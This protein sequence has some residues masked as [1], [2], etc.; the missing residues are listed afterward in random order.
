MILSSRISSCHFKARCNH[1]FLT[2][3]R[4][5]IPLHIQLLCNIRSQDTIPPTATPYQAIYSQESTN[6]MSSEE[7]SSGGKGQTQD[8]YA[9]RSMDREMAYSTPKLTTTG[10]GNNE[11]CA[12]QSPKEGAH[13]RG[14]TTECDRLCCMCEC[15]S[16]DCSGC[17]GCCEAC[18]N[19]CS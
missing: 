17:D 6:T 10:T 2:H 4:R 9:R 11:A 19:A 1:H 14:G 8:P 13:L 16:M 12:T 7:N 18:C 3:R 15:D 5:T